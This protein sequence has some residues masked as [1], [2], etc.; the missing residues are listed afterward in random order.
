MEGETYEYPGGAGLC[1]SSC[2]QG[3]GQLHGTTFFVAFLLL[4]T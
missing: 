3:K 4:P 1:G 2:P